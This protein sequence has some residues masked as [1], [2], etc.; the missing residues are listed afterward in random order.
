MLYSVP[1]VESGLVDTHMQMK[2][3]GN[4]SSVVARFT[5]SLKYLILVPGTFVHLCEFVSGK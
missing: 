4:C 3:M 1:D 2:K 5:H